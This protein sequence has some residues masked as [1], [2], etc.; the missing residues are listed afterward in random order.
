[1]DRLPRAGT[2][3]ALLLT[4]QGEGLPGEVAERAAD[5]LADAG[6]EPVAGAAGASVRTRCAP[7]PGRAPGSGRTPRWARPGGPSAG[8]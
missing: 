3:A 5:T 6:I 1:M 8:R 2:A 7:V 4:G